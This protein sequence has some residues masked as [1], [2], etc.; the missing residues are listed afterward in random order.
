MSPRTS[1]RDPA[2][3]LKYP[4]SIAIFSFVPTPS[5]EAKA[6]G[7]PDGSLQVEQPAEPAGLC[8][9]T[10]PPCR[11]CHGAI[12]PPAP[13]QRQYRRRI[14]YVRL[15]RPFGQGGRIPRTPAPFRAPV[16]QRRDGKNKRRR[17]PPHQAD[18]IVPILSRPSYPGLSNFSCLSAFAR[19]SRPP[20]RSITVRNIVDA[21]T[22]LIGGLNA[23]IAEAARARQTVYRRFSRGRC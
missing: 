23:A 4:V 20:R 22:S 13:H 10:R 11:L 16:A 5:V 12:V 19:Q 15:L 2:R 3:S 17:L 14:M 8:I 6:P 18:P 7:P 9:R 1:R 21:S